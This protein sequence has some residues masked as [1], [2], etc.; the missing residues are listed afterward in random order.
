MIP[1][2]KTK[3]AELAR[4]CRDYGVARLE[5]FGSAAGEAF[6]T[7]RSDVDFL[8]EFLPDVDLGPWLTRYFDLRDELA[9]LLE[10]SVDLV[11][12]SALRNPYFIREVNRTRELLYAA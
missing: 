7:S 1:Q 8:V 4:L 5:V 3:S 10:R 2:L 12:I 9:R 6:D 11:M